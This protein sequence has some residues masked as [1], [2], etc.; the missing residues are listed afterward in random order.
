MALRGLSITHDIT[1][2]TV[3]WWHRFWKAS[4]KDRPALAIWGKKGMYVTKTG[5][6]VGHFNQ[7]ILTS[8]TQLYSF[9]LFLSLC[10][11]IH[12]T[13]TYFCLALQQETKHA[14]NWKLVSILTHTYSASKPPPPAWISPTFFSCLS[15]VSWL[16][17]DLPALSKGYGWGQEEIRYRRNL[18]DRSM[19]IRSRG[20]QLV[21]GEEAQPPSGEIQHLIFR[22]TT[23][24]VFP[25]CA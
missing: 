20:L 14:R 23:L 5:G 22:S 7:I 2:I 4:T 6:T 16:F 24:G 8:F 25:K 15:S 3:W 19:R 13:N 1:P 9:F 21:H 12:S 10:P 17:Q 18:W 11:Y